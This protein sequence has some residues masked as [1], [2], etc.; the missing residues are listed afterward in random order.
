[1][2]ILDQHSMMKYVFCSLYPI[3]IIKQLN[4]NISGNT[5]LPEI[6]IEIMPLLKHLWVAKELLHMCAKFYNNPREGICLT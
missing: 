5:N 6:C 1:M 4:S 2:C 3:L